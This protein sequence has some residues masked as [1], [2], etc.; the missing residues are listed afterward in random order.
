MHSEFLLHM[1]N[2]FTFCK[3][4]DFTHR[5]KPTYTIVGAGI[6]PG[7]KSFVSLLGYGHVSI[8]SKMKG[9]GVI[10]DGNASIIPACSGKP[11]TTH[12]DIL[13]YKIN[14]TCGVLTP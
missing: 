3:L 5:T 2:L 10:D 12:S 7:V 4:R 9:C 8:K 11:L 1:F 14:T 6:L 13:Q